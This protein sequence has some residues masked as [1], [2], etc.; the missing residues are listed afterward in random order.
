MARTIS[1]RGGNESGQ[2]FRHRSEMSQVGDRGQP[3]RRPFKTMHAF[4]GPTRVKLNDWRS[5]TQLLTTIWPNTG[6]PYS[7][8]P[9]TTRYISVC[10]ATHW[11]SLSIVFQSRYR[12]KKYLNGNI[13][14][15]FLSKPPARRTRIPLFLIG[16]HI[17]LVK[18]TVGVIVKRSV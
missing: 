5:L 18:S 2:R 16:M 6:R 13:S 14:T 8:N 7:R 3:R 4:W 1:K 17:L 10:T 12:C 15:R 11:I 9:S